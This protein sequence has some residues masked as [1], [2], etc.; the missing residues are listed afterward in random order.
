MR[1]KQLLIKKISL[2]LAKVFI[3]LAIFAI[4]QNLTAQDPHFSLFNQNQLFL[5]PAN[6]GNFLGDWRIGGNYRN[7]WS[8]IGTPYNTTTL[9]YDQQFYVFNL[10]IG[11]GAYFMNDNAG[12]PGMMY[13]KL[14]FSGGYGQ[15]VFNNYLRV[16]VQ[17]GFAF[18]SLDNNQIFPS[19]WDDQQQTY[20]PDLPSDAN[21]GNILYPDVNLGFLWKRN[22]RRLEPEVGVSFQ[23]VNVPNISYLGGKERLPVRLQAYTR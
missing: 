22:I 12:S 6:T 7:Q 13:N 15:D 18:A 19:Q 20:N 21:I 17:I 23:H 5:N 9:S 3:V 1:H 8:S 11:G 4:S 2:Q 10:P 14:Y 16:G